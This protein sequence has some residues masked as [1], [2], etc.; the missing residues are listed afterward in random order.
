MPAPQ[1]ELDE[2]YRMST[3]E[4]HRLI[5]AGAFEDFPPCEL[6]DGD[7]W[8]PQRASRSDSASTSPAATSRASRSAS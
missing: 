7:R 5:D 1:V 2:L 8:A 6:I 3:D 4:Y